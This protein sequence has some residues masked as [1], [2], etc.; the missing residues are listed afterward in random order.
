MRINEV[1]VMLYN[2][3]FVEEESMRNGV[4]IIND[5][6]PGHIVIFK[7]FSIKQDLSR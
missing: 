4:V 2:E 1:Y 3:D 6:T 5:C 7:H